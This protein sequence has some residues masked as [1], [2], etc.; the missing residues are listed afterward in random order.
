VTTRILAAAAM[1]VVAACLNW[2]AS[3][4][5][6]DMQAT[7]ALQ[8]PDPNQHID[9][10]L[11]ANL[12]GQAPALQVPSPL[13]TPLLL[14]GT[15]T[16][17]GP[18]GRGYAVIRGGE[19]ARDRLYLIGDEIGAGARLHAVFYDHVVIDSGGVLRV[20]PLTVDP[21]A[22]GSLLADLPSAVMPDSPNAVP[23][24]LS[25]EPESARQKTIERPRTES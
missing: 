3:V 16:V 25:Q 24:D 5:K 21:A 22:T 4:V 15:L 14:R 19:P 6:Q 8:T 13:A 10:I 7:G 12:F 17:T 1:F 11:A 9:A 18:A 2:P 23:Y 20:L